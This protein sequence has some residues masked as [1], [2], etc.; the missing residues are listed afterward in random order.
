MSRRKPD[1]QVN[2][3][4]GSE[5]L[6]YSG[7][8][9]RNSPRRESSDSFRDRETLIP[10][11][12]TGRSLLSLSAICLLTATKFADALTTGI[13]LTYVPK[14]Y[15]ANPLIAPVLDRIGVSTGLLIS[16]FIIVV[17]IIFI[18]EVAS[19]AVSVRRS[20]GHLAPVVRLVGYGIPSVLFA[21]VS[22][23]NIHVLLAGIE[24]MSF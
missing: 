22:I 12:D 23:Y 8:T 13:G 11:K 21:T 16:S 14:V 9:A 10:S 5:K 3:P 2:H 19:L 18:T 7:A 24:A 20:D 4:Q 6:G 15:E 1:R 17:T